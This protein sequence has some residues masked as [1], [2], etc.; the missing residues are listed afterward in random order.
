MDQLAGIISFNGTLDRPAVDQ[1]GITGRIDY[2]IE[3]VRDP[4]PAAPPDANAEA[5]PGPTFL[6]AVRDQLGLKLEPTKA[7]LHVLVVDSV[8]R[9]TEN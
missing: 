3:F 1:T 8:N 4:N 7:P 9:P 5:I 2:R 6:Q